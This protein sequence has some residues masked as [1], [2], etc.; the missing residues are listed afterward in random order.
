MH[1]HLEE[2]D[3]GDADGFEVL[4]VLDPW[5]GRVVACVGGGLVRGEVRVRVEGVEV[6]GGE[7]VGE[8]EFCCHR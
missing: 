3:G 1:D 7:L 5:F 8:W 6:V 2:R 4:G